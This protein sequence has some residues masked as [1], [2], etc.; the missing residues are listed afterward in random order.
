MRDP[1]AVVNSVLEV[2]WWNGWRGPQGWTW[3]E[4]TPAQKAEWEHHHRSF[5]G[6]AAIE[7]NILRTATEDAKQS[8]DPANFME[9]RYE[10]LCDAPM[11]T[12]KDVVQFCELDW[13]KRFERA[14]ASFRLRNTNYK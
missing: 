11:D 12:F 9:I 7:M 8:I 13:S 4:L 10:D 6:L 5:A 1:R 14:I 2:D 3:G